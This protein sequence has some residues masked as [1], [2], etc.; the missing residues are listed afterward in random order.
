MTGI[1]R[2]WDHG[3]DAVGHSWEPWKLSQVD[4]KYEIRGCSFCTCTQNRPALLNTEQVAAPVSKETC[5]HSWTRKPLTKNWS[6]LKCVSCNKVMYHSETPKVVFG[7]LTGAPMPQNLPRTPM[8]SKIEVTTVTYVSAPGIGARV[9]VS[10]LSADQ[11]ARG[12]E[13]LQHQID[14]LAKVSTKANIKTIR[15]RIAELENGMTAL[16][17]AANAAFDAKHASSEE[18]ERAGGTD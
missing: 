6:M 10:T 3:C 14:R 18:P 8:E 13:E 2:T 15:A 9:D 1:V 11:L 5:Q 17:K 12:M 16:V 7:A 4:S